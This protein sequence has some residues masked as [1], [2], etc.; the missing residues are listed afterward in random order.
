MLMQFENKVLKSCMGRK[1]K[2]EKKKE[3]GEEKNALAKVNDRK[4]QSNLIFLLILQTF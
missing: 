4:K 3:K 2:R 1:K